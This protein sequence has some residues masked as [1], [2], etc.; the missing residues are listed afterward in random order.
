M[1]HHPALTAFSKFWLIS[2]DNYVYIS[3]H[4]PTWQIT[5]W[6]RGLRNSRKLSWKI[7]WKCNWAKDQTSE[8]SMLKGTHLGF[9][10]LFWSCVCALLCSVWLPCSCL[11]CSVS[12][13]NLCVY[14]R[15]C[16]LLY[17]CWS[18]QCF[19]LVSLPRWLAVWIKEHY[20]WI[21]PVSCPWVLSPTSHHNINC[22]FLI[23]YFLYLVFN[24]VHR[25]HTHYFS[26]N[27][28]KWCGWMFV[29][30]TCST[31]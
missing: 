14:L 5:S 11:S 7:K 15:S 6:Q 30:L 19:I 20:F 24:F 12:P 22:I 16:L 13:V 29:H 26:L 17:V 8:V 10:I 27:Q 28:K 18:F 31:H 1:K 9:L 2:C 25:T 3:C 4:I 23:L 21:N